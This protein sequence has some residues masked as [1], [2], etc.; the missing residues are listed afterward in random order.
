MSS[1][2]DD[3]SLQT[4]P[5]L[6][7]ISSPTASLPNKPTRKRARIAA[8]VHIPPKPQYPSVSS[9]TARHEH[10]QTK[11]KTHPEFRKLQDVTPSLWI[12]YHQK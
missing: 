3:L 5:T 12:K 7:P 8:E 4:S 1:V 11:F 9:S 2:L 10:I 6:S